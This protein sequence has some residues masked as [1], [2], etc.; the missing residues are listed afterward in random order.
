MLEFTTGHID[1]GKY[2]CVLESSP[3]RILG[4]HGLLKGKHFVA[5]C[6]QEGLVE[7]GIYVDAKVVTDGQFIA[8]KGLGCSFD[9]AFTFAQTLRLNVLDHIYYDGWLESVRGF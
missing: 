5:S 2:L 9:F 7:E 4:R 6:G 3:V 8:D 1:N